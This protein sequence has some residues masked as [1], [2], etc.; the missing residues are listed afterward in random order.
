VET[1]GVLVSIEGGCTVACILARDEAVGRNRL[2][3]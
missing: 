2:L 1:F 3:D